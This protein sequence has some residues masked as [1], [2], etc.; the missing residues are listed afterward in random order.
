MRIEAIK[1]FDET[2]LF[3]QLLVLQNAKDLLIYLN[4]TESE[5]PHE[6]YS[7]G[8]EQLKK[9]MSF[10]NDTLIHQDYDWEKEIAHG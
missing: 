10:V 3:Q 6:V 2:D 8:T 1:D 7:E 9:A 4:D 5:F